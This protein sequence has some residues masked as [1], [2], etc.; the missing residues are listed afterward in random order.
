MVNLPGRVPDAQTRRVRD[1]RLWLAKNIRN[2]WSHPDAPHLLP[3]HYHSTQVA[4]GASSTITMPEL[5]QDARVLVNDHIKQSPI[6]D[7]MRPRPVTAG[8]ANT[9]AW[10]ERYY[11]DGE[12]SASDDD[13]T[14]TPAYETPDSV[15]TDLAA[16]KERRR[17]RRQQ[18]FEDEMQV[19]IGLAHWTAQRNLWTGAKPKYEVQ[20]TEPVTA[21]PQ[22]PQTP[23]P[24]S[25]LVDPII[26]DADYRV[27]G[28]Q[29]LFP[30]P[31]REH[32]TEN[33]YS[34][35]YTKI[36]LQTRT[37]SV[38][39]SLQDVTR[40][41]VYGWKQEGQWPPKPTPAEPSL[42]KKNGHPHIKGVL[43][44]LGRPFGL[45][46][47]GLPVE[48]GS[49]QEKKSNRESTWSKL[50]FWRKPGAADDP[51]LGPHPDA[52]AKADFEAEVDRQKAA[53]V[54]VV[55]PDLETWLDHNSLVAQERAYRRAGESFLT[56]TQ[57]LGQLHLPY[58]KETTDHFRV[59]RNH[60][61]RLPGET[62]PDFRARLEAHYA[63]VSIDHGPP[64]SVKVPW[65]RI[66]SIAIEYLRKFRTK[67]E[68]NWHANYWRDLLWHFDDLIAVVDR[69]DAFNNAPPV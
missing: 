67:G 35:I 63:R 33:S 41:L 44:K 12:D 68:W 1:H 42:V 21:R 43:N 61:R 23:S 5:T 36:I 6:P 38:P 47:Q 60:R 55:R 62:L 25:T 13:N 2:D 64:S 39:I 57:R 31:I 58:K 15:A 4:P 54:N 16:R 46:G 19:N 11:S 18:R 50:C 27:P 3:S 26:P 45:K 59:R 53:D 51:G 40:S 37:P 24:S 32:I 48:K 28:A 66:K 69:R 22:S 20:P 65:E 34:D 52:A 9:L 17:R 56:H 49:A 8:E 30:N 7:S 29:A 10:H 14:A